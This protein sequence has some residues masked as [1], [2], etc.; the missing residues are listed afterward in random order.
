MVRKLS[1]TEWLVLANV[2]VFLVLSIIGGSILTLNPD[3]LV[4]IAQYNRF[5]FEQGYIWE[6]FTALFV[7]FD[8][9]HLIGNMIFLLL[10]CYRAEDFFNWR[11]VL[12]IYI[13]S[14][15]VGNL[16]GLIFGPDF[17]SAGASGAIFGLLGAL[18]YPLKKESPRTLK[19]MIFIGL[20]FLI[21]S[22]MN[23]NVDHISHWVGFIVGVVLGR[24][25]TK[26]PGKKEQTI[27]KTIKLEYA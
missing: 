22:G 11:R 5:I 1:I 7:H 25:F 21:F 4:Y 18:I 26:M 19:G 9:A 10:F 16:L 13:G 12:L 14:G 15:L 20:I 23:Y 3:V 24:H 27:P 8:P 17:L 6:L 2:S